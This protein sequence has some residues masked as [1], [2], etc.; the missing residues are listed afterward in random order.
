MATIT[1]VYG[2]ASTTLEDLTLQLALKL[3]NEQNTPANNP[4]ELRFVTL[5]VNGAEKT[6]SLSVIDYPCKFSSDTLDIQN[7]FDGGSFTS[8]G[9]AFPFNKPNLPTALFACIRHQ[10]KLELTPANNPN[11][12]EYCNWELKDADNLDA[13]LNNCLMSVSLTDLPIEIDADGSLSAKEYLE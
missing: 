8:G 11:N 9:G 12:L 6:A 13:D 10:R 2:I 7:V 1:P 3:Q 5:S 4:L